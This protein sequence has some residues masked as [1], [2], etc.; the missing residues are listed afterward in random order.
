MPTDDLT[1]LDACSLSQAIARRELSAR[2]VMQAT[3][4]RIEA[5]TRASTRW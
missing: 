3:L 4:A 2:E 1:A 5:L